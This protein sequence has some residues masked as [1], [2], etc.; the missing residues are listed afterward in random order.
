MTQQQQ[1]KFNLNILRK[2]R[3]SFWTS[4][5]LVLVLVLGKLV[6]SN[7]SATWGRQLENIKNETLAVKAENDR[8]RLKLNQQSGRLD[9]VKEKA[10][11]FGFV[12]KPEY[13]YLTSGESVAQKLP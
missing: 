10:L 13:L 12:E 3:W 2:C 8:L 9:Q 4:I 7:R 5:G 11:G 1:K 6:L